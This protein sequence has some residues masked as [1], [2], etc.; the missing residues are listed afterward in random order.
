MSDERTPRK[1]FSEKEVSRV[2]RRATELQE[3]A[4]TTDPTGLTFEELQLIAAEAGIDPQFMAAA[5]SELE[6]EE[7]KDDQFHWLG[8]PLSISLERVVEGEV[9]EI[10]WEEMV[11]QIRSTFNLVGASGMVGRSREWTHDSKDRQVQVTVTS[12]E[13]QSKLR[14]FARFPQLAAAI[15]VGVMSGMFAIILGVGAAMEL[16]PGPHIAFLIASLGVLFMGLRFIYSQLIQ[17]KERKARE[18]LTSMEQ[19]MLTS[20]PVAAPEARLDP[21]LMTE[22]ADPK[23]EATMSRTRERT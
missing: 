20:P 21:T 14:I 1:V 6:I 17:H 23:N 7:E 12:R 16:A 8:A 5:I 10:Q 15:F 9:S 13:G 2:L 22:E 4:K 18:L 19:I 3:S 11:N